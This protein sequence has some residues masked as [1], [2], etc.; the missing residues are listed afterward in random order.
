MKRL[1]SSM[2]VPFAAGLLFVAGC[3]NG[4]EPSSQPTNTPA[5]T[6]APTNTKAP[7]TNTAAPTSTKVPA[8]S[9]SA[10]ATSTPVPAT[11]TPTSASATD[12]PSG[13]TPTNTVAGETP[14][15]TPA[16][17][18]TPTNTPGGTGAI[19]GNNIIEDGEQCDDGNNYGGD[20]C[21]ANCTN[22]VDATVFLGVDSTTSMSLATVQA[23]AFPIPLVITGEQIITA[24]SARTEPSIGADGRTNFNPGDIP[25]VTVLATNKG[26][27][28]PIMVPGL[29]CACL[30][31]SELSTCGGVV[32]AP[33][34]TSQICTTDVNPCTD[35]PCTSVFGPGNSAA[36]VIGCNGISN[37]NTTFSIDHTTKAVQ[38]STS[39]GAVPIGDLT[40]NYTAIA[41]I[42]DGGTCSTDTS[43]PNKGPDGI[44]C[45]D[46]DPDQGSPGITVQTTGTAIAS[47]TNANGIAGATIAD[48]AGC[49]NASQPCKGM[50][51][52]SI[53]AS[54]ADIMSGDPSAPIV[55]P[56]LCLASAYG[57]LSQPS[58]G[59][60]VVTSAFC[61]VAQ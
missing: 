55:N 16:A 61:A 27:I 37:I 43:D 25:T 26:L 33:G 58:V 5:N 3:S 23:V 20:G 35:P 4:N 29:V 54:C 53:Q 14:T 30:R 17:I 6:A 15:N 2:A 41:T 57:S 19:C 56:G 36:G 8:T 42:M 46:D 1:I 60:I 11:F 39:G 51:S 21:A 31:G 45:T 13:G 38:Y 34:D 28:D 50:I 47:V 12:T 32:P 9:T 7:A 22:E 40:N 52:G 18:E 44:P 24:G 59:D 10:P 48:G 49:P